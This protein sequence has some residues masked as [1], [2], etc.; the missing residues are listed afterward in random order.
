MDT[1]QV[2]YQGLRSKNVEHEINSEQGIL[3]LQETFEMISSIP[4]R[5][6]VKLL[7]SW[8]MWLVQGNRAGAQGNLSD[9]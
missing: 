9:S 7:K 3:R 4:H 5:F 2:I 8:S 1:I 6:L